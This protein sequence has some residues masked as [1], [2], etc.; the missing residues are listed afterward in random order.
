MEREPW[1]TNNWWV[2][3]L[4]FLD[5]VRREFELPDRIEIHD[6]TLRDGEQTP[7]IVLRKEEKLK[8]AEALD[9]IGIERI[10]AGMP[11]VSSEDREAIRL[12]TKRGMEAKVMAFCRALKKD[13]DASLEC[14]VDGVCIEWP[15]SYPKLKYQFKWTEDE[16]TQKAID[17]ISY[18]KQHGLYTVAFPYD[19]TRADLAFLEEHLKKVEEA[20]ADSIVI[21]DT[22]GC[23]LPNAFAYL[24]R[25]VRGWVRLPLEVHVHND[26]GL[27][28]ANSLAG[29]A[30]GARVVHGTVNGIGERGG[31]AA[32]EE[33]MVGLKVLYGVDVKYKFEKL[34]E[35]SRLV[36]E[37]TN[38]KVA[39]NKPIVGEN[40]FTR[41]SG[42]GIRTLLEFPLAMLPLNPEFVGQRVRI[43]LGKKSGMESVR[44]K[45]EELGIKA[46]EEEM[47][48]ILERVKAESIKKKSTLED[49]EF[50]NIVRQVLRES[51]D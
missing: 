12:I 19:T 37:L 26:L 22:V 42:I 34:Y 36:E 1:A 5:D 3:H 14:D 48:L 15:V 50:R 47:R 38:F 43:L 11:A 18:A 4:N 33:V 51:F 10:E 16:V 6:A 25:R 41:E 49:Q 28:T 46:K 29:V 17:V 27:A 44:I 8:I 7:G 30:A 35:L 31:N 21:V 23:A 40:E 2:S 39:P 45:L 13:I 24:V 9:E 32:I 20:G